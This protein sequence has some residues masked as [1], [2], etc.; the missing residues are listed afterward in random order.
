[1]MIPKRC[2]D[3]THP[4]QQHRLCVA[5]RHRLEPQSILL[6]TPRVATRIQ[7]QCGAARNGNRPSCFVF[8]D[9]WC[10]IADCCENRSGRELQQAE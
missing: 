10:L 5:L 9:F 3:L 4:S 6:Q 7:S 1:M 8:P 2:S